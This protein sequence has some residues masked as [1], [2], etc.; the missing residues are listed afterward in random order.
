MGK[1]TDIAWTDHTFPPWFVCEPAIHPSGVVAQGCVNCYAAAL[2]KRWKYN[3]TGTWGKGAPR[4]LAAESTWKQVEGWARSA[5]KAGVRR[6][7]FFSLGDPLD[8]AVPEE[9]FTRFMDLIRVTSSI[10]VL[11]ASAPG[12]EW[13]GRS[14]GLR[15]LLL[16]KRPWLWER[17][18]AD[19]RPLVWLGTS[20][21]DQESW[22]L[23]VGDLA[24]AHPFAG[25]RFVSVEPMIGPVDCSELLPFVSGVIVGGE[26]GSKARPFHMEWARSV[27]DQCRAAGVRYFLK[28]LGSYPRTSY[29]DESTREQYEQEGRDWPM[30]EGWSQRDGQ[31]MRGAM[32]RVKYHQPAGADPSEWPEDLR[33]RELPW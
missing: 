26:S 17:I 7:V 4:K 20:A 18:P 8:E 12:E 19:V 21:S 5:A 31:P 15:H 27:R 28:Q 29:Y 24:H 1:T 32:V 13:S 33:V 25:R 16:T 10:D 9:W 14:G 22:D 2:N 6:S 3:G 11:N 23:W 30:P